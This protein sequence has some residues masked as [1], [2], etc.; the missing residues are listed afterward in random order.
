MNLLLKAIQSEMKA[1]DS[2]AYLRGSVWII[3]EGPDHDVLPAEA[4]FPAIG[5]TDGTE[6]IEHRPG[7]TKKIV[8]T[9]RISAYVEV[10]RPERSII[11]DGT[12]K[13]VIDILKDIVALLDY[14]LLS[15]DGYSEARSTS[16]EAST[17]VIFDNL[18]ALKKT[19]IYEYRHPI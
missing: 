3:P 5:I 1:A 7:M 6:S 13:G 14:N 11:G 16:V 15:L 17:V 12:T 19:V 10:V 8:R 18:L 4:Q 9:V 2:L